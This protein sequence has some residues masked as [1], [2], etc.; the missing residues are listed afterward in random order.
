MATSKLVLAY[1]GI[2]ARAQPIRWLL[3]YHKVDFIDKIYTDRTEWTDKDKP[4]LNTDFPNLPYI[5]DGDYVITESSAVLQYAAFKTGN[6]DLLGKN[7]LDAIKIS[8]LY[9]FTTDLKGVIIN[10]VTNKEYEKIRDEFLDEK[11]APFLE[12]VSKNLGE[13]EY[14]L[15]YLTYADFYLWNYLDLL[16][17]MNAKYLAKWPNLE[18]YYERINNDGIKAY[19]K[20]ENYPKQYLTA[21]YA[22]WTGEEK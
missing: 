20:T 2:Q 3:A 11:V 21:P 18:K 1:W 22:T 7:P 13:K 15:G 9:S 8:Q 6:N 17:R 4:A 19:R 10:L 16:H 14:P 12:K 5:Q